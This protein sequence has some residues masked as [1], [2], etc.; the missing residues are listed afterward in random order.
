M[1]VAW[2]D[3][4]FARGRFALMGSVVALVTALVV[5][6]SGLTAG[7]TREST[8]AIAGLHAD[9]VAFTTPAPGQ[10][11]SFT[12]STVRASQWRRWA[13]VP[14]VTD[15]TPLGISTVRAA[16]GD[17]AAALSAFGVPAGAPIASAARQVAPGRVVLST[18]AADALG[19]KPGAPVTIA[20]QP[21]TVAAI[22]GDAS[23]AHTPVVWT[24][25]A[26]WQRL[27]PGP[28]GARATVVA[29]RTTAGADLA[30]ADRR[31][32][33]DAVTRSDALDAIDGHAAENN[34]LQMMRGLLFA[35]SALVIGAFFAVWTV[36]RAGDLAIL[37]ALGAP[38]RA[39]LRDA[40]GQ[41]LV[42]LLAGTAT[43]ALAATLAGALAAGAVPFVLDAGTVLVPVAVTIVLGLGGAA[44]SVRRIGSID[45]LQA[46]GSVR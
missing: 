31:L 38:V 18:G 25:L 42:L 16:A 34:S 26:D 35:I 30:A 8:S 19:A 17:R 6:L 22:D 5:L 41:A 23:F 9:H 36:Q 12:A 40:L 1:F 15:A 11:P 3:L 21:L 7:L 43:G 45:P 24:T 44:L 14:G 28:A 29:L 32:G 2:R 13:A 37:R 39:L 27:V 4:R 46:L 10:S 20:G 33:T